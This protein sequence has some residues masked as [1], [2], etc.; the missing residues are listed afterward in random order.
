MSVGR[1]AYSCR[2]RIIIISPQSL[3]LAEKQLWD[4]KNS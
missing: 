1:Y 2:R 3:L 4:I